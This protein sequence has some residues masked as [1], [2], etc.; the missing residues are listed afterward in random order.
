MSEVLENMIYMPREVQ[1]RI[2][3]VVRVALEGAAKD[4]SEHYADSDP[5]LAYAFGH[6]FA[7]DRGLV[8]GYSEGVK[9]CIKMLESKE[10]LEYQRKYTKDVGDT[11]LVTG[12]NSWSSWLKERSRK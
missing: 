3:E 1:E 12:T 10:A 8:L 11:P 6:N 7:Y 4:G 2:A 9:W 5:G